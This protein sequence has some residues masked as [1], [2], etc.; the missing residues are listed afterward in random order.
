MRKFWKREYLDV[1]EGKT[2]NA[3]TNSKVK[4]NVHDFDVLV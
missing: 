1:E 2:R 4:R 3:L